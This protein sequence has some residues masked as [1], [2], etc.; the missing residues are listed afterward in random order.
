MTLRKRDQIKQLQ[1]RLRM[2]D[3]LLESQRR[4]LVGLRADIDFLHEMMR[5][6]LKE[7]TQPKTFDQLENLRQKGFDVGS[8]LAAQRTAFNKSVVERMQ[9]EGGP[10]PA[11]IDRSFSHGWRKQ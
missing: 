3:L 11:K 4:E 1:E 7:Q 10:K 9:R 2:K 5:A 6:G 8:M